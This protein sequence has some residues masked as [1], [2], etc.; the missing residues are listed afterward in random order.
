MIRSVLP[1]LALSSVLVLAACE[2]AEDKAEG[3]YQSALAL[4]EE[5]DVDRALIEL[6]N[7]F[8]YDGFHQEARL[9]Y[10][11][12]LYERGQF[13]EANGQYLRLIEQYPE[14]GDVRIRLAE[15]A[16][17]RNDWDEAD[18]HGTEAIRL[19]PDDTQARAIASAL[20]YRTS[21][22]DNDEELLAEAVDEAR[23]VLDE[24][25]TNL[26]AR[27]IAIASLLGGRTPAAALPDLDIII[28]QY[29]DMLEFQVAKFQLL[30]NAGRADEAGTHL[31]EMYERFPEDENVRTT[32]VQWYVAQGD[33][34]TTEAF[35]RELAGDITGE[36]DGHVT[37][38]QFLQLQDGPDAAVAELDRLIEANT[39]TTNAELYRAMRASLEF[40]GGAQTDA[41]AE[42]EDILE[43]AEPSDQ[44][45]RIKMILV[46]MLNETGDQ[47]GARALVEDVIAED[48]ANV[49][50]LKVRA[51]WY[52]DE[53]NP[54]SALTD[55]RVALDQAP[56]DPGILMLMAQAHQRAGQ[57]ELAGE[58]LALAVE[59]SNGGAQESIV[60][61]QFLIADEQLQTAQTI[62]T[63][64]RRQNPGNLEILGLLA[65]LFIDRADWDSVAEI[66]DTLARI[67]TVESTEMAT[68][69]QASALLGQ[70]RTDE[71]IEFLQNNLATGSNP[72]S[73]TV[74]IVLTQI[75]SGRF[76]Q[77]REYLNE[78]L[79]ETP[80]DTSLRLLDG[81]MLAMEGDL[82]AA[83]EIYRTVAAENPNSATPVR[84]LF[85]L[86]G[87][88]GRMSDAMDVLDSGIE[89]NPE[90]SQLLWI[91]ASVLE[92]EGD[93]D[94][95]IAIYEELYSRNSSDVIVANNLA[96]L[97]A[98]H[99]D[100]AD[101]LE[102]AY[103]IARRLRGMSVPQFQDTY[104]WI[105]S[106][107]GDY[108]EALVSLEPAAVG[109]P[110]DPLVQYHLGM[111]YAA[112][113]QTADAIEA[114]T[115][116]V[117]LAGDSPLPQFQTA[118]ETLD[119]LN[120]AE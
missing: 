15:S 90:A 7:V 26:V 17:N 8:E 37:V 23:A 30:V 76:D 13:A 16:I 65:E 66:Q 103:I 97:L 118:R 52:I 22:Q 64:A 80:D 21:V 24:D 18:R 62:L 11:D 20:K 3:Y 39:G 27:R 28:E 99:R 117:E 110:Q 112:L 116:A 54:E 81:S 74:T 55:L 109:L 93:I 79:E 36:T 114:L 100:D 113:E 6:R 119:Q 14:M 107:R 9:L 72:A 120:A 29:P 92:G 44:T 43:A 108:E 4:M 59:V 25:P 40:T 42:M 88:Q 94:G 47:V 73:A 32:L 35:L 58:R 77:A 91:K 111:T 33:N 45:R 95:A 106:R 63:E 12:T 87:A 60:Y 98:T 85:R 41:I 56:R 46:R 5:G 57:P 67:N 61:A 10:A 1:A 101:S 49:D 48:S 82:E 115:R 51:G 68:A 83:E 50:A 86:L 102:Q 96:S 71:S 31:E 53:D 75:R 84:L 89:A 70:N 78:A 104:G 19:L 34:E 2:S 105:L 69:L 38:V